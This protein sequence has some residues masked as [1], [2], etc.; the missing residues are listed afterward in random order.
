MQAVITA[1]NFNETFAPITQELPWVLLPLI[2]RPLIE[3]T[4]EYLSNAGIQEVFIFCCAHA[5]RIRDHIRN[6]RWSLATSTVT[7]NVISSETYLSVGDMIRDLDCK[8]L[9]RSDF[10][11]L[12]GGVISTIPLRPIF[13][14]HRKTVAKDKGALMTLVYRKAHPRHKTRCLE[15]ECTVALAPDS[16]KLL[17]HQKMAT[18]KKCDFPLEVFQQH[19]RVTI[20]HD[21]LNTHIAICSPHVPPIFSDNFDYQTR[22]D[23][24]KGILEHEEIMGNSIYLHVSDSCYAASVSNVV[25]YDSI[26]QD[27]MHRWTYPLVP[28]QA[29]GDAQTYLYHRHN[30]YKP[31]SGLQLSRSCVIE[32]NTVIGCGTKV[33]DRTAIKNSVIGRNCDIGSDVKLNGVYVWDDVTIGSNCDL[34]TCLLANG[35]VIKPGVT[36]RPGCVLSS[37]VTVGPDITLKE[38]TL[39]QAKPIQDE[40]EEAGDAVQQCSKELVGEEGHGY[41]SATNV[42]SDEDEVEE[43]CDVWGREHVSSS[44]EE[45][46]QEESDD[47]NESEGASPP[48]DDTKLFYSEVVESLQRGMEENVKCDNLILEINSSRYA[49]NITM[50]G[51]IAIVARVV[52]ELPLISDEELSAADYLPQLKKCMGHLIPLLR[53]YVKD[54]ESQLD[55]LTGIEEFFTVHE[56]HSPSINMVLHSLY[57]KDILSEEAILTWYKS[58]NAAAP[59]TPQCPIRKEAAKF[60]KW[61]QE[62]EEESD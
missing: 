57:D 44:E 8:G 42:E 25:M 51:V 5:E 36:V 21:L 7:V 33:G 31:S 54:R 55:C 18:A 11:L 52:V 14:E 30:V 9:I 20:Y 29:I 41:L 17:H 56:E 35:V 19:T 22:E 34:S 47:E 60:V 27:M 43:V 32:Q 15:D 3:Y 1:D 16:K 53:N 6:S 39:L 61:L 37:G 13:E 2:N 59:S 38:G 62:A 10:V 40:F 26:S 28:D 49:Y 45:S 23:F 58:C 50:K 24:V 48:P 12:D 46:Q 4:L